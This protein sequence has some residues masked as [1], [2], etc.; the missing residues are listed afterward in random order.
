MGTMR[1]RS[2]LAL[3]V[4]KTAQ[5]MLTDNLKGLTIE[6]ALGAA[7]GYRSVAA[8][9]RFGRRCVTGSLPDRQR[10]LTLTIRNG[11]GIDRVEKQALADRPLPTAKAP[12]GL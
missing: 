1:T 4:L 11:E 3:G 10:Q 2:E 12:G 7:G 6:E 9:Q 5:Q 8:N